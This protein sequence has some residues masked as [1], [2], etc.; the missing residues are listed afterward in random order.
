MAFRVICAHL[1]TLAAVGGLLSCASPTPTPSPTATPTPSPTP[2]ADSEIL[3]VTMAVPFS[4]RNR[5]DGWRGVLDDIVQTHADR[6]GVDYKAEVLRVDYVPDTW[7]DHSDV[8]WWLTAGPRIRLPSTPGPLDV[9]EDRGN[10]TSERIRYIANEPDILEWVADGGVYISSGNVH[11]ASFN[12]ALLPYPIDFDFRY[13]GNGGDSPW[14][15]LT[16]AGRRAMGADFR[17][18][19]RIDAEYASVDRVTGGA[20]RYARYVTTYEGLAGNWEVWGVAEHNYEPAVVAA[21]YGEGWIILAQT[22][23]WLYSNPLVAAGLL[24]A[25]FNRIDGNVPQDSVHPPGV[26]P[27]AIETV[28]RILEDAHSGTIDESDAQSAL[29]EISSAIGKKAFTWIVSNAP[30]FDRKTREFTRFDDYAK[31]LASPDDPE[32]PSRFEEDPVG[33]AVDLFFGETDPDTIVEWL[34]FDDE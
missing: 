13:F 6:I 9:L 29:D 22:H 28:N 31:E 21:Q 32:N 16:T 33:T 24:S 20:A 15:S 12:R 25:A 1:L 30:V 17:W 4:S 19:A 14:L 26:T 2:V 10:R 18:P 5:D 7:N 8:L 23:S 27:R 11:P 3:H 34:G